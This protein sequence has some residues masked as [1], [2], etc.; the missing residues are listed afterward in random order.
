MDLYQVCSN[1]APGAKSGPALGVTGDMAS[2]KKKQL[3]W[4]I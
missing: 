2:F 3:R 4:A 1:Y